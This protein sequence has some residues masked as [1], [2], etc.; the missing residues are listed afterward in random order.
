MRGAYRTKL[1]AGIS[2][3]LIAGL[4]VGGMA[5]AT[6]ATLE[7]AKYNVREEHRRNTLWAVS[8]M[9]R[10]VSG[11]LE[12]EAAR[13][14]TDYMDYHT[15]EP[16]AVW[17]EDRRV[18]DADLAVL[19]SPIYE[20]G[21]A[22]DWI[23]LYFQVYE[24]GTWRSPQVPRDSAVWMVESVSEAFPAPRTNAALERLR[25]ELPV[26]ELWD[27]IDRAAERDR[28]HAVGP[29][30]TSQ[31]QGTSESESAVVRHS[32]PHPPSWS[33]FQRRSQVKN[34][35]QRRSV[36]PSQCIPMRL[37]EYHR[38]D[39]SPEGIAPDSQDEFTCLPPVYVGVSPDPMVTFWLGGNGTDELR[40]VFA[41]TGYE[42]DKE[43][44][45]GFTANWSRLKADVLGRIAR[46]FPEADLKPTRE[47]WVIDPATS[48]TVM[49]SI[50]ARLEVP[51]IPGGVAMAAWSNVGGAL[52]L[53]WALTLAVL[54]LCGWG[55]RNLVALTERRMQ[56]AYAVTHELRTPLTTFRLYADMLSAGLVPEESRQEYLDT[57]N[58]ES[59]R[60]SSLVESVLEYARLENHR[61]RLS[62]VETNAGALLETV[63]EVLEKRC[64]ENSIEARTESEVED[65]TIVHTDLDLITQ[66]TGVLVNNACRHTRG[67]SDP[68][69]LVRLSGDDSKLHLD[70]IDSGCGIE[71]ADA[72]AVFKPFRRGRKA[73]TSAQG[74]IGLG[75][76]LAR[77]WAALLGGRLDLIARHHATYG[78]AH[79]RLTI[80][81]R[82]ASSA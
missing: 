63:A 51:G 58:R 37:V 81:M 18:R 62:P 82:I 52:S 60:L 70:V 73:S 1:A 67:T 31:S 39:E 75:L 17:S 22:K 68:V 27:R 15:A 23:D 8:E 21:P 11:V 72:R 46:W 78:G 54:A 76:S 47:G 57:L 55:L 66:I 42:N 30:E 19:R 10:Y 53:T 29:G 44:K 20:M 7:L 65:G 61:V 9:D 5:W 33:D 2:F 32:H 25:E 4:M 79:F 6:V 35:A 50:P 28:V 16:V 64:R 49:T 43:V 59:I 74:G 34:A 45:Q 24:D 40:L 69:V 3:I 71:R 48:E 56:F 38:A 41:R 13:P 12:S 80:P 36:P 77:N 26:T 14:Y